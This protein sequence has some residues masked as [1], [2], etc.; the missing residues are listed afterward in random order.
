MINIM[1]CRWLR[2]TTMNHDYPNIRSSFNHIPYHPNPSFHHLLL[3]DAT[4]QEE[5]RLTLQ[6]IRLKHN[7][8]ASF[9]DCH[10]H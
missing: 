10:D 1:H 9:P 6:I 8:R 4:H 7:N 5:L 3:E 2:F